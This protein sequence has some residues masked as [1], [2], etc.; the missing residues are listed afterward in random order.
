MIKELLSILRSAIVF[1][2][3][4]I[5]LI[6]ATNKYNDIKTQYSKRWKKN[7]MIK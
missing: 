4:L 5:T 6:F 2:I 1:L 3:I 7:F